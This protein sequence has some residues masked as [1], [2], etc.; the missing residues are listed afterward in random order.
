[1]NTA[2]GFLRA[3]LFNLGLWLILIAYLPIIAI[4]AVT[5]AP[6]RYRL[7]R[8]WNWMAVHWLRITCGVRWKIE[9]R[10]P[11][12]GLGGVV[13]AKHQS[14]WE[15]FIFPVL[16]DGP[17]FVLKRELMRLP[18]FGWGLAVNQPIAIDR[19]AGRD[20]LRQLLEQGSE[21]LKQGRWVIIF[22][23]GTRTAVGERGKYKPGGALLA[24]QNGARVL[25][26]AHNAGCAWPRGAFIKT[27][28]TITLRIGPLIDTAGRKASEINAEVEN[29]IEAQMATL[30]CPSGDMPKDRSK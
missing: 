27:P 29:W 19:S 9:G 28:M 5:P 13:L 26:I 21:R 20:A 3:A 16:F 1:M 8:G 30:P 4:A 14:T 24:T 10:L 6:R 23:E 11:E 2:F 12:D 7:M 22:P 18:I 25:P 15:T 17:A